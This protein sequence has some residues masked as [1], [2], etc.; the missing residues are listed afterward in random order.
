MP[1]A[2]NVNRYIIYKPTRKYNEFANKNP[3]KFTRRNRSNKTKDTRATNHKARKHWQEAASWC[4]WN[5][6]LSAFNIGGPFDAPSP[7]TN[8]PSPK[9]EENFWSRPACRYDGR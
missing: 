5:E 6:H 4:P 8:R 1:E 7:K 3:T 9:S 2:E